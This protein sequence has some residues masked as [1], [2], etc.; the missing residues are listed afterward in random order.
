MRLHPADV[1]A[2]QQPVE[3]LSSYAGHSLTRS[4]QPVESLC[5]QPLVP[6]TEAITLPPKNLDAITASVGEYEQPR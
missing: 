4:F 3:L 5:L 6:E 2:V 1:V